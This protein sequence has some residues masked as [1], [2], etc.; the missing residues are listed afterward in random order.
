MKINKEKGLM[1]R[2]KNIPVFIWIILAGV[3]ILSYNFDLGIIVIVTGVF[4]WVYSLG[5][6]GK[7][8]KKKKKL[9]KSSFKMNQNKVT[10]NGKTQ[11]K[12]KNNKK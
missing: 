12:P 8:K 2:F 9:S 11:V 6:T 10:I 5:K 4:I 1:E 7:P 3:A